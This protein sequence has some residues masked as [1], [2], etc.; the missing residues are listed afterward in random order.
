MA[1]RR[2]LERERYWRGVIREQGASGLGISAFCREREVPLGDAASDPADPRG[3]DAE[4]RQDRA[5]LE[6]HLE[7]VSRAFETDEM[8]GQQQ[9]PGRRDRN[10][11]RQPL[12]QAEKRRGEKTR[13]SWRRRTSPLECP[14]A[15]PALPR[16][17]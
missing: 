4:D 15:G 9:V 1:R 10:E 7:G 8:P 17:P 6:D 2:N 5:K 14:D 11:L 13:S 3:I 16:S 12:E